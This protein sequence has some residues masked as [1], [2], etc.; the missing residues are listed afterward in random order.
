MPGVNPDTDNA[1]A[2]LAALK[3]KMTSLFGAKFAEAFL[4]SMKPMMGFLVKKEEDMEPE[5]DL[6]ME[7]DPM[8]SEDDASMEEG[9]FMDDLSMEEDPMTMMKTDSDD[10]DDCTGVYCDECPWGQMADWSLGC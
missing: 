5:E 10:S 9:P 1:M 2:K 8:E 4:G 7:E 3:A 6:S